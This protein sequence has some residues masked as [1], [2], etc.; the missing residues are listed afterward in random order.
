V[1]EPD[2]PPVA[3]DVP[4][5]EGGEVATFFT[6]EAQTVDGT[7]EATLTAPDGWGFRVR[8]WEWEDDGYLVSL[9][10]RDGDGGGERMARCSVQLARCILI[11]DH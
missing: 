4:G 1:S 5:T 7:Q 11:D 10:A 2:L 8:S 6:L 3:Y 9:V